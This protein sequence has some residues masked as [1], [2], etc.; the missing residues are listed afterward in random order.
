MHQP[1]DMK[2]M[3]VSLLPATDYISAAASA[4]SERTTALYAYVVVSTACEQHSD[5]SS[6]VVLQRANAA[7][8]DNAHVNTSTLIN[9]SY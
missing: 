9:K 4:S 7:I 1:R 6:P 2:Q 8:A 3:I 5:I